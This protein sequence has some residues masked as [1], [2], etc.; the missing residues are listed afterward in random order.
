M[1]PNLCSLTTK[2]QGNSRLLLLL[3]LSPSD[4]CWPLLLPL[5]LLLP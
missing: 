5:L 2:R 1:W 4:W 3:L